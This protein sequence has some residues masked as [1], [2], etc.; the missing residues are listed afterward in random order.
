M[1]SA[2]MSLKQ[3]FVEEEHIYPCVDIGVGDIL[4]DGSLLIIGS[5][6]L[7]SAPVRPELDNGW[8]RLFMP[9]GSRS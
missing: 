7:C 8:G 3:V 5:G 9:S 6:R 1:E 4:E 2:V